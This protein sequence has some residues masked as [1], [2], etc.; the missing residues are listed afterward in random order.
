MAIIVSTNTNTRVLVCG[1]P[2]CDNIV[3]QYSHV[4]NCPS[5]Y[6]VLKDCE[7]KKKLGVFIN[8]IDHFL[9]TDEILFH[10]HY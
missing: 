3:G 2:L 5:K 8:K 10:A 6:S 1:N 4:F 9:Y 7:R